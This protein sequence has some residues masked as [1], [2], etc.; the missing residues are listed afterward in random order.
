MSRLALG[1]KGRTGEAGACSWNC[2]EK[3]FH[4]APHRAKRQSFSFRK[5]PTRKSDVA[6]F[7]LWGQT[8]ER[9]KF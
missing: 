3:A 6:N 4:G 9:D 1:L 5:S 8:H 2:G 7:G